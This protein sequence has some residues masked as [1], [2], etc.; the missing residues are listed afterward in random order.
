MRSG[1]GLSAPLRR[2][3]IR[4]LADLPVGRRLQDH[5]AFPTICSIRRNAVGSPI[6]RSARCCGA[7]RAVRPVTRPASTSAA[8]DGVEK[9]RHCCGYEVLIQSSL[10]MEGESKLVL[11]RQALDFR[12]T[13]A[14]NHSWN[15]S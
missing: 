3:G 11:S 8:A 6:R 1:I 10:E 7:D 15:D 2:L 4:V 14:M 9:N 5:P 12:H 13:Q